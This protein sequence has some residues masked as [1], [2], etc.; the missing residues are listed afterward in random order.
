MNRLIKVIIILGL[1]V[2]SCGDGGGS[3]SSLRGEIWQRIDWKTADGGIYE[4]F[5]WEGLTPSCS[6]YPSSNS[7]EFA[8]FTRKGSANSLVVYFQGG[9]ACW[10]ENNCVS[11]TTYSYEMQWF[12]NVDTLDLI[13]DGTGRGLGYSGIFDFTSNENPFRDWSFVYIP[14]CTGDL[15]WGAAD[16]TYGA[17]TIRHR[18]QVN[19][20]LILQWIEDH[21][22]PDRVMVTGISG[23]AYGAIFNFPFLRETFPGA[24]YYM[25]G[26]AGNGVLSA[27]F[28]ENGLPLWN[29]VLPGTG[30]FNDFSGKDPSDVEISEL[31]Y[32]I[33]NHYSDAV[34]AQYTTAW[35]ENQAYFYNVM[36][37]I[38]N[39]GEGG[40]TWDDITAGTVW[41]DWHEGML[42][43][44][45]AT[46]SG[47]VDGTY[48]YYIAPGD[49]H[50]ILMFNEFYTMT[51]DG[52]RLI[53][54][55][56]AMMDGGGTFDDV[57][58]TGDCE[59]PSICPECS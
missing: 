47:L 52:V 18:G 21:F 10:H 40:A 54:F 24:D 50:T 42:A 12:E 51:S 26:D 49:L 45:S 33:A 30:T 8:F 14:Y 36:L 16:V 39:P 17:S 15:H 5:S 9:G 27:D 23:G 58:C 46:V 7:A 29:A 59:K 32:T 31:Y 22:A 4:N 2:Q 38:E 25:L 11:E 13:S 44:R 35:D 53:D 48:H 1:I 37:N 56:K 43:N 3:D 57:E 34:F 28:K 55:V 41:C 20:R 6:N 19:F